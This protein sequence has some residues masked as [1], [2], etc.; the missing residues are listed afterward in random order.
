MG[1]KYILIS[2][3]LIIFLSVGSACA[4]ETISDDALSDDAGESLESAAVTDIGN[5]NGENLKTAQN[6]NATEENILETADDDVLSEGEEYSFTDLTNDINTAELVLEITHDYRFNRDADEDYGIRISQTGFVVNGNNHT[7]DADNLSAIFI[8]DAPDV[9]INDLI[10]INANSPD[11]DGSAIYINPSASLTTNNV[12]FANV[13]ADDGAVL[14]TGAEYTSNN[15]KFLDCVSSEGVISCIASNLTLN[16]TLMMTSKELK[17]GLITGLQNSHIRIFNSEFVNTTSKYCSAIKCEGNLEIENS[18]FLNLYA[19][20]TAGAIALKKIDGATIRNCTFINVSSEKNAGAIFT[21]AY[22]ASEASIAIEICDSNFVNCSSQFGGAILQLEANLTI[23]NCNFTDNHALFDGGAIY[24]SWTKLTVRNSRFKNNSGLFDGARGS[25][26]GAIY[27]DATLLKLYD[28]EF[29]DNSAQSGGAIYLYDSDYRIENNLFAN[30]T[31]QN[32]NYDDIYTAF[33]MD[34]NNTFKNNVVSSNDS[35]SFKNMDYEYI[36]AVPGMELNILNNSIETDS[37]PSRFDLRDWGWATP[38]RD[39]GRSGVCWAFS[40]T[41][42]MEAAILR[43]LGIE[44]DISENNV[45]DVSLKYSRF[46]NYMSHEGGSFNM[47]ASYALSWLGV[48]ESMYDAYDELGKISPVI[49]VDSA[50]HLQDFIVVRGIEND[51]DRDTIKKAI[52]KYGALTV[53]YFAAQ[54]EPYMNITKGA[55]YCDNESVQNDHGVVLIG[56]DDSYSKDNFILTPPGDG[57]WIFKN[58][59]GEDV[60]DGGYFY[61]SYYDSTFLKSNSYAWL[62]DNDIVY[63]KNYQYDFQGRLT[64]Y[65]FTGEYINN[66]VAVEDDLIAAVGTYFN[67]PGIDY[68]VEIYV[69]DV[70]RHVQNGLSPFEGYHTIKLDSYVPVKEGDRFSVKIKSNAVP[71]LYYSRQ[72]YAPNSSLV[73]Y[74]GSW[75]DTTLEGAVCCIKAYT[76]SDDTEI[77]DNSNISV[78]Y[79]GGSCFSVKVVTADG[80][81]VA[82]GAEVEFTINGKTTAVKTDENGTAK[83]KIEETPKTYT[84]TTVYK[85]ETYKNTV[86]VKHVLKAK[87]AAVKKSAKKFNLKAALKI[88]GKAVKGKTVKFKFLKKT[89]KATTNSRGTA[90]ITIKKSVIKKLKKGKTYRV[91]VSYGKDRVKTTVKVK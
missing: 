52:L 86:T 73:Y 80:H 29:K 46:G 72:N 76:L 60:G 19:N 83:I 78:D 42:S 68:T 9:V 66:Y 84:I 81:A 90:K 75:T 41:G 51:S 64:F 35:A 89:Y 1:K 7:I 57:A 4:A 32:G 2:L 59:W 39:Q 65:N 82:A 67:D 71:A 48:F 77:T 70:L 30:N 33:E 21:D 31:N 62:F 26:G 13:T 18:T 87:K 25:F 27:S 36:F 43:Y 47:G 8:I 45:A 44:M 3:L 55:Q 10:L 28:C 38:V 14:L 74:N 15:D 20:L 56:W 50:I 12:V 88:N 61:I 5:Y 22:S 69:N 63:E 53:S 34:A 85:N 11:G 58:S 24:T 91:K 17:W 79:D 49:A 40:A 6:D 37:I 54:M 16:N 23:N